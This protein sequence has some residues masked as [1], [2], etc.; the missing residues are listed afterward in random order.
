MS[1]DAYDIVGNIT[2]MIQAQIAMASIAQFLTDRVMISRFTV[3]PRLLC[4]YMHT[5]RQFVAHPIH[6]VFLLG[7]DPRSSCSQ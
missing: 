3:S 1:F 2:V 5:V 4:G 6:E 7:Y